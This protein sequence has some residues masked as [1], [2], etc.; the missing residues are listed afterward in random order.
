M[1]LKYRILVGLISLIFGGGASYFIFTD[2]DSKKQKFNF[3]PERHN[4]FENAGY[5]VFMYFSISII[6]IMFFL[7]LWQIIVMLILSDFKYANE[8]VS[9]G[10]SF[11]IMIPLIGNMIHKIYELCLSKFPKRFDELNA[12]ERKWI[13]VV[14]CL[15]IAMVSVNDNIELAFS[16]LALMFGKFLWLDSTSKQLAEEFKEALKLPVLNLLAILLC[17]LT[18]FYICID[19]KFAVVYSFLLGLGFVIGIV[20]YCFI[21]KNKEKKN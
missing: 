8:V 7:L 3:N 13:S 2:Q 18:G 9:S 15:G 10:L 6:V 12:Q 16:A 20:I 21:Q 5:S 4:I 14:A 11:A 17:L 19:E 1:E